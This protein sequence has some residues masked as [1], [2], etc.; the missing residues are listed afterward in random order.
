MRFV[1][2]D[3]ESIGLHPVNGI[4]WMLSVTEGKRTKVYHDC[5]G[6]KKFPAD[7]VKMLEDPTVC[8]IIH[9]SEFDAPYIEMNTGI[10]VRNFWDSKL[11]ETVIQGTQIPRKKPK[12]MSEKEYEA[13]KKKH[14]ASL[15]YVLPRYGFKRPN[16]D[17]RHHFIDRKKGVKFAKEAVD[18]AKDDTKDLPPIQ[19]AQEYL[20]TRD[21]LLEV[22]L[23][24]NK[25]AEVVAQMKV[26]GLG[27]D[28]TRWL[29]VANQNL[30]AYSTLVAQLP[31]EVKNWNSHQQIK[32]FFKKR[33]VFIDSLTNLK[34]IQSK[35]NDK[36]L[37]KV[38]E[39]RDMYSDATS[40]GETWLYREDGSSTID[41]DGRIR[42]SWQQIINTGRFATNNPNILA[43][44]KEGNQRSAIIPR[45]GYVFVIGD[46]S[47]QEIGIMAVASGE[48]Q[49]VNAL[50]RGESVHS[51]IAMKLFQG[52]WEE[53]KERGCIAPFKCKCKGH[54]DMPGLP[55][56][57]SK[58]LNFMLAYG[59]GAEKFAAITGCDMLTATVTVRKYK[60]LIPNLNKW[61]EKNALET[62]NT[63]IVYS[64]DPYKRRMVAKGRIDWML[65]NQG[66]NYPV[67]GA[68]ANMLKLAMISLPES[69][70]V[71]LPFHDELVTEVPKTYANKAVKIMK[72]IMEQS[73]DYITGVKG[74][75]K[76]NPRVAVNFAK[77]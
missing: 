28:K 65:E 13:L 57:K 58:K 15:E 1:G 9:S 8:K 61:L 48:D 56:Y 36:I 38:I 45:K 4:I 77:Q 32:K 24:E 39:M 12:T 71:V 53:Y 72:S 18:Y 42:C 51:L 35:V 19:Q 41:P 31:K 33:G 25:V 76:V 64:A 2:I 27:I 26:R 49:W 11:C 46:Y 60:K 73:A 5:N 34:N 22:A 52:E 16:K 37:A 47:G 66:K 43:L 63:G 17:M 7:V 21:K 14:S 6:M 69:V 67:Q 55:Y 3:I 62:L 50:M 40:Y 29:E 59:G 23:L 10:R 68:G 75:I 74:V 54:Q 70:P 20:L 44:P 30:Q